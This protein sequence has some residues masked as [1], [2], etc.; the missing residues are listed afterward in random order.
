MKHRV[1]LVLL[2]TLT[3]LSGVHAISFPEWQFAQFSQAELL[4]PAVSGANANPAGDGLSNW[5]KYVFDLNPHAACIEGAPAPQMVGGALALNFFRRTDY[6][7]LIYALEASPDLSHWSWRNSYQPSAVTSLGAV[8][9]WTVV[10][11]YQWPAGGSKFLRLRVESGDPGT[12]ILTPPN[13]LTARTVRLPFGLE[14]RWSDRSNAE[15]GYRVERQ[16]IA[17]NVWDLFAITGQDTISYFDYTVQSGV[18][19]AYRVCAMFPGGVLSGWTESG[20]VTPGG[21]GSGGGG[22]GPGDPGGGDP[23]PDP[24]TDGDTFKDSVDAYPHDKR[25]S[26]DLPTLTYAEIDISTAIIGAKDVNM[27]ALDDQNQVAFSYSEAASG[28][29]PESLKVVVWKDGAQVGSTS[30]F[31]LRA[32]ASWN[33]PPD[34]QLY[35]A[36]LNAA[37]TIA[38]NATQS[39]PARPAVPPAPVPVF[40]S[41][42]C[43][44]TQSVGGAPA[45]LHGRWSAHSSD[46][47]IISLGGLTGTGLVWGEQRNS[48]MSRRATP[49]E[50]SFDFIGSTT[51][52]F[53]TDPA[54]PAGQNGPEDYGADLGPKFAPELV[55]LN[56]HATGRVF[57]QTAPYRYTGGEPAELAGQRACA[58]GDDGT[59]FGIGSGL[60]PEPGL[61]TDALTPYF[62]PVTGGNATNVSTSLPAEFR[63]QISFNLTTAAQLNSV[64]D[65]LFATDTLEGS[66]D[67]P[68]WNRKDILWTRQTSTANPNGTL[69]V[70]TNPGSGLNKDRL[71]VGLKQKYPINPTTGEEDTTQTAY[72]A[73]VLKVPVE[74]VTKGPNSEFLPQSV[75][76]NSVVPPQIEVT[77]ASAT[78]AAN[79]L[80]VSVAGKVTD[81]TSDCTP[82]PGKQVATLFITGAPAEAQVTLNNTANPVATDPWRPYKYEATFTHNLTIPITGPGNYAVRLRTSENAGG[83]AGSQEV[84]IHV[85]ASDLTQDVQLQLPASFSPAQA[86]TITMTM[87][88]APATETVTLTE[89]GDATHIF[90]GQRGSGMVT[91]AF[92]QT[93]ALTAAVDNLSATLTKSL[94]GQ[95]VSSIPL[96][97]VETGATTN[98]FNVQTPP[99]PP[100]M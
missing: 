4:N 76:W 100:T 46:P 5:L 67:K 50:N 81:A 25:R 28:S 26:R 44:F 96:A 32:S 20:T 31:P 37:G 45:F 72:M 77:A 38:G 61:P 82:T 30:T 54:R 1:L 11:P 64:G 42:S 21:G 39:R 55:N 43:A 90:S 6:P 24:D 16:R 86:D 56:Q 9:Q 65:L 63:K 79:T 7:Y 13:N 2:L 74:F 66:E 91:L 8:T 68:V 75:T 19:Y 78:Y 59:I 62:W 22:P 85:Q 70:V 29:T 83:L 69:A 48:Y 53:L 14:L 99:I 33:P 12:W 34:W 40:E 41:K 73:A 17:D 3:C 27:I 88:V 84:N 94:S 92:A 98:A 49:A 93:P 71:M 89:T 10:D 60:P 36:F 18:A 23:G 51:I 97:F 95:T 57:N 58:L 35:P 52:P 15:I 80:T 87:G 47:C